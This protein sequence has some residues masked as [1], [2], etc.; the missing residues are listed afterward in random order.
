MK[1]EIAH[2]GKRAWR[3]TVRGRT[4]HSA[5]A[6]L[7]VN[8]V[9]YAAEVVAFLRHVAR[10]HRE[11]G[12]FDR[13]YDIA[14]STVHTGVFRGGTALNIV[15]HEAY[16]DFEFRH[17]PGDDPDRLIDEVRAFIRTELLPEMHAVDPA[18]D[19]EWQELSV[20]PGLDT[21]EHADVV[22]LAKAL[23]G[24]RDVAKVSFGTE[25]SLFQQ[26]GIT[27]VICGPGATEQVHKA[28]EFVTLEQV[29]ACRGFMQRLAEKLTEET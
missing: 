20:F 11:L 15:P 29:A 10:R 5:Y 2:K 6:P 13:A 25:G 21:D 1:P 14:H 12:P 26:A 9:E 24:Q 4:C 22:A 23:S 8:A 27:S 18:S 28:N 17:L 16:F 3:C 19:I 7:G